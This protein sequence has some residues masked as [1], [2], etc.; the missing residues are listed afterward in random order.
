MTAEE[1]ETNVRAAELRVKAMDDID[2]FKDRY[3][4]TIL[5]ALEAGLRGATNEAAFEAYVML[6]DLI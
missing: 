6:R 4:K 5:F 1:F 2:G 3:P